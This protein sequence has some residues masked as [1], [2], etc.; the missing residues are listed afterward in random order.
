MKFVFL[1]FSRV[2]ATEGDRQ[3]HKINLHLSLS[4]SGD[5][6]SQTEGAKLPLCQQQQHSTHTTHP[7]PDKTP[8]TPPCILREAREESEKELHATFSVMI[9]WLQCM[10]VGVFLYLCVCLS[11]EVHR[12]AGWSCSLRTIT[13]TGS[14]SA[15]SARLYALVFAP[16]AARWF[17]EPHVVYGSIPE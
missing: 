4:V 7:P 10:C 12:R 14:R 17:R 6:W 2:A 11:A 1:T 15:I 3:H 13:R 16:P 5:C 9:I 8:P